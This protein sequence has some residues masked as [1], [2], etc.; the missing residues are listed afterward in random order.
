MPRL[1]RLGIDIPILPKV[2]PTHVLI[3][4]SYL[5]NER[6]WRPA[7]GFESQL[8]VLA[9]RAGLKR[10]GSTERLCPRHRHRSRRRSLDYSFN[11]SNKIDAV[12]N[13]SFSARFGASTR[14]Y[15]LGKPVESKANDKGQIQFLN[16]VYEVQPGD[17][18][19]S[20][21]DRFY[22]DANLWTKIYYANSYRLKTLGLSS[23]VGNNLVIP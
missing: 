22:G 3:D 17:T 11:V 2:Y 5:I 13:I 18:L 14:D 16:R 15:L 1:A 23:Q 19:Q 7:V 12:H 21:A 6:Q 4:S 20:I 9:V 8:G 10:S